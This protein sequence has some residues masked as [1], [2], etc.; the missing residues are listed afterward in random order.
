[1]PAVK[2]PA[3]RA[4]WT[5]IREPLT[6]KSPADPPSGQ[7]RLLHPAG[8]QGCVFRE[9][10]PPLAP[11]SAPA[12]TTNER[13]LRP[14][15]P[16]SPAD[17]TRKKESETS[18]GLMLQAA[19]KPMNSHDHEKDNMPPRPHSPGPETS[20]VATTRPSNEGVA[21]RKRRRQE[22]RKEPATERPATI[23]YSARHRSEPHGTRSVHTVRGPKGPLT[24][25]NVPEVGLEPHS[26]PCNH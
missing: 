21:R 4:M 1:M 17:Q 18:S 24:W 16:A 25:E 3:T 13:S 22:G 20:H 19:N 15:H 9:H 5:G 23:A 7:P 2:E 10:A 12:A 6:I 8:N 14:T 26:N 11:A